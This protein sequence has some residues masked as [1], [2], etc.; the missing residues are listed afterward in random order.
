MTKLNLVDEDSKLLAKHMSESD[1]YNE[2]LIDIFPNELAATTPK[3]RKVA[4]RIR[5]EQKSS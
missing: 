4:D 2:G 1:M 5:E 3:G